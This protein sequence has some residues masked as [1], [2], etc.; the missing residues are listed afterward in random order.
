MPPPPPTYDLIVIGSGFAGA[1]TTLSFLSTCASSTT[2]PPRRPRVALLE[3][4]HPSSRPGASRWTMAYLRLSSTL[5]FDGGWAGEMRAASKGAADEAYMATLA[6]EATGTVQWLE[7]EVG[8]RLAPDVVLACGGFEGNP[9]M[10]A[11]YVG[12]RTHELPL[13]A[14]G[15]VH[16]KGA[17]LNMALELG[18]AT[19]G[20]FDGMHC[21]L[22]DTRATKPDAVIW[23]HNYGIVVNEH[24][25]RFYDEGKGHLF[26][27]FEKIALELWR[28]QNQKGYFVTD[29]TIMKRF[30]PGWVYD[31]TDQEPEKADTI[32]ELAV[33]LG[34][35]PDELQKTVDE[36]NEACDKENKTNWANPIVKPPFY[37]YPLMAHLTFTYG[38]VKTNTNAQVLGTNDVPIPGLWAAGEMTG[39]YYNGMG[40][41]HPVVT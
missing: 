9:E 23:G 21:E 40:S 6:R 1:T 15:L 7:E 25:K 31:T 17:G 19:S 10:L 33:K 5:T 3:A 29:D 38:G 13:I 39:L 32:T 8:V 22:V 28:D 16:N 14:P 12:N 30:R 4:G 41:V 20:S 18:A 37:G 11:K 35:D 36:F 2:T 27:T 24:C 34:C 26:S